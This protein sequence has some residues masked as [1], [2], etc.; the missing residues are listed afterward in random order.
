MARRNKSR[1]YSRNK[2]VCGV[3]TNDVDEPVKNVREYRKWYSMLNRAYSSKYHSRQPTYRDVIVCDEWLRLSNFKA[4]YEH[5]RE[6]YDV[7]DDY[8]L[9]KDIFGDGL[10]YSPDN[11][12]FVPR[13]LNTFAICANT[14]ESTL[15]AGVIA[16]GDRYVS[17][18]KFGGKTT[19]IGYF[20]DPDTAHAAYLAFKRSVIEQH[21][22]EISTIHPLLYDALIKRFS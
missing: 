22:Q 13:W 15:P 20:D 7:P 8:E 19:H 18:A 12:V 2:L 6:L 4:W 17:T 9:D 10:V 21:K 11:C 14:K 3:G 5:Q 16:V 1:T